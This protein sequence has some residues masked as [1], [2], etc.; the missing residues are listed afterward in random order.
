M[1]TQ[2]NPLRA[3]LQP[4][5]IV[6]GQDSNTKPDAELMVMQ[7][8]GQIDYLDCGSGISLA[9]A[10]FTVEFW[11]KRAADTRMHVVCQG[12]PRKHQSLYI[13]WT[14]RNRFRFG[15]YGDNLD[16]V[17]RYG[18]DAWHHWCCVYD[19]TNNKRIIYLDGIELKQAT[20]ASSYYKG[21]GNLYIG[22][23][24]WG[25]GRDC[26]FK[27]KIAEIRI[28]RKVRTREEIQADMH[29]CLT[30]H[31]EELIAYWPLNEVFSD[32]STDK[33]SDRTGNHNGIVHEAKLIADNTLPIEEIEQIGAVSEEPED[34]QDMDKGLKDTTKAQH[35]ID[36]LD[37]HEIPKQEAPVKT[38]VT[39][40][41]RPIIGLEVVGRGIYLRPRLPYELKDIIFKRENNKIY[42]SGEAKKTY[43]IPDGYEVNDSPPM[44]STQAL[45]HVVIEESW[46]RFDKNVSLD[47]G[48]AVSNGLFSVDA[49]ASQMSQVRSEKD[50]YYALRTSFIPLWTVYLPNP[51][52][53]SD[54]M[55][56]IEIPVPFK[57]INRKEYERFFERYGTHYVRRAWVGGKAMLA[58][59]IVKSSDMSKEDVQAGISAG[60]G[61]GS[62]KA[63]T[64]RQESKEKLQNNSECAVFGKGG[65]ELQLAALSS[66]D[67]AN[68]NEWLATIKDNPQSIEIEVMGIWTLIRDQDKAKALMD[69]YIAATTFTPVS[70]VFAFD[71]KL[72][73]LRKDKYSCYDME[74]HKS[75]KPKPIIDK[76]PVLGECGFDRPDAACMGEEMSS[77]TGEDLTRKLFLF[78][79]GK[80]VRLDV[81]KNEIDEGY[82]KPIG[83]G[84]PGVAFDRIDAAAFSGRD[85]IYFFKGN[86]YIRYNIAT[87]SVDE[88]YPESISKRWVGVNFDRIDAAIYWGNGKIYFFRGD[89]HI[90][91]DTVTYQADPGYPKFIIGS[92]VED[93]KFFD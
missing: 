27:G 45:N 19:R 62:G 70:A 83:E 53:V 32:G 49:C 48:L 41:L 82:P 20:S 54:D 71:K 77:S 59:T 64:S 87:N 88:G 29:K 10:D 73:F 43:C 25:D 55:F 11:A 8:D 14:A 52:T 92:Y 39:K 51:T 91:Y 1:E 93:W 24:T 60:F 65:D 90:R 85:E 9:N 6:D 36:E 37:V 75:E 38:D 34:A 18:Y 13:G 84:W 68:Y 89:Q 58:F 80:Y 66:L 46:E 35:P 17:Q 3:N 26:Y 86:R 22:R 67:E 69:A 76:W 15:F 5:M 30:G 7:F 44:P 50:C 23:T 57:H 31:E 61:V 63:D 74:T 40:E 33:A 28:W 47:A 81:D 56:D 42:Y 2:D 79:R 4:V 21:T 72:Y 12:P 78:R 16:V